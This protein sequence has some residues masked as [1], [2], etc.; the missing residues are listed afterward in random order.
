MEIDNPYIQYMYSYPHKTAYEF[1]NGVDLKAFLPELAGGEN[2]L[3]F[4]IPFCQYKCGY[5][6]LF[7]VAGASFQWM[8]EYVDAM[9]RQA[10]QLSEV[11]PEGVEFRDITLGGGTPLFL[12]EELL[13]RVF[14]I[15]R[16]YFDFSTE[17]PPILVE[18]SPNQTT[19]KKLSLLKRHGATRISIGVQSF[20]EEELA[21]LHRLHTARDAKQAI[22]WIQETGF[23][24]VN[25]DLIYGIPGQTMESLKDSLRQAVAFSPE[26][27]FVYP[28]YVKPG[29]ELYRQGMKTSK[30]AFSMYQ[31]VRQ[32]LEDWGYE[33]R[34]MR[35]FIK[36]DRAVEVVSSCGFENTL[37][38]GCGGRSYIG[39]LHFCT[40]YTVKPS[41]CQKR[42]EEYINQKD[43]MQVRYGVVLSPEERRRRF[44]IKNVLFAGGVDLEEYRERFERVLWQDYPV[45]KEWVEEGY[46]LLSGQ[47]LVLSEKGFACSDALGPQLIS[48]EVRQRMQA[49]REK[50]E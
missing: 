14:S 3:Y 49:W 9:Q 15:A 11:L 50:D 45:L 23:D 36:K 16:K 22:Q 40:P 21:T 31:Y 46:A 18:T 10:Q 1:L 5:C 42:I 39:N 47:R 48:T 34:S 35:R 44:V 13:E 29:T 24:C 20:Q 4:H 26:E 41:H 28:L 2:S 38:L 17:H 19:K 32:A 25:L 8:E 43:Y 37:A 12:P 30:E 6:N 27:L 7:S 33:P